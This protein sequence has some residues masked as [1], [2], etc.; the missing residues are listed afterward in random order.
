MIN[1]KELRDATGLTQA[2]FARTWHI[3]VSTLR[4]WEQGEASP[5]SYVLE[6][7]A[8][9]I[10]GENSHLKKYVGE[11][12]T[13]YYDQDRQLLLDSIGNQITIQE[14]LDGIP[15]QNLIIY[16][17][18]LFH[19]FYLIQEKFNRDIAYDKKDNIIWKRFGDS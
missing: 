4:K 6:L 16:I 18:D 2:A 17:E 5:P 15:Q 13:F 12:G 1:I 11:N 14:D 9:A 8:K 3:P 19:D 10:P 7:L